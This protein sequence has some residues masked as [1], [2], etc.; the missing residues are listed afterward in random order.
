MATKTKIRSR[1]ARDLDAISAGIEDL[2][3]YAEEPDVFPKHEL[4]Y[5]ALDW[6]H[7][8]AD[9]L[10]ELEDYYQAGELGD[11]QT[12]RYERLKTDLKEILPFIEQLDL[13][14]PAE[15]LNS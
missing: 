2:L 4:S 12:R 3:N 7:L 6:D 15:F 13:R 11:Q 8:M 1:A 5:L 10:A 9:Y 14:W